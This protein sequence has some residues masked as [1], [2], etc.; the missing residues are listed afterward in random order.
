MLVVPAAACL[1]ALVSHVPRMQDEGWRGAVPTTLLIAAFTP[2]EYG[3]PENDWRGPWHKR[4]GSRAYS[5]EEWWSWQRQWYIGRA[6]ER[7]ESEGQP[8]LQGAEA[9][10][11]DGRFFASFR[12]PDECWRA[13]VAVTT[14]EGTSLMSSGG[15][16]EFGIFDAGPSREGAQ[17]VSIALRIHSGETTLWSGRRLLRYYGSGSVGQ[18]VA[19]VQNPETSAWLQDRF[20]V[21]KQGLSISEPWESGNQRG[22]LVSVAIEFLRDGMV[23]AD[24]YLD[25]QRG[26]PTPL[27]PMRESAAG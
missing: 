22:D 2:A 23:V 3:H 9:V 26:K 17:V 6:I 7:M 16:N 25:L 18:R 14:A 4:L 27:T 19:P 11:T 24:G 8:L 13:D 5:M 21:W 1:G 10:P 12:L 15:W 20:W